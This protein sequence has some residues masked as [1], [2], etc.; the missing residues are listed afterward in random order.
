[1]AMFCSRCT[2]S[3]VHSFLIAFVA[4]WFAAATVAPALAQGQPQA[5]TPNLI[6]EAIDPDVRV[7]LT[8]N[9]HPLAQA[10]Y[11]QGPAPGSMATGRIMLVLKRSDMQEHALRQYLDEL[12]NP[13]SA[14]YHKWLTPETLGAQYGISEGDLATVTAWLQGQGFAIDKVSAARNM[15]LFSGNVTQI[16]QAFTTTIHRYV[17]NGETHYANATDPQIPAALAPVIAAVAPL[18]DFRPH[19]GAVKAGT[20]H[21]DAGTKRISPDITLCDTTTNKCDILFAVP[22]D[23]AT[24]YDTPNST[25]NANYAK[26]SSIVGGKSYDGTGVTI[27]V[28]GDANIVAQD[29]Q[30][31][32]A[33]FLPSSYSANQPKV[34][35]DEN[36]PGITP[37]STEALLDLQVSGGV[38]PGA[39]INFY[40]SAN[41]GLASG[42]ILAI[43]RAISDNNASILN[44]SFGACEPFLGT[45]GNE[46]MMQLWEQAAAQGITVA[47]ATG[48]S[49]SAG[50]DDDTESTSAQYG[51]AVSGFASTAFNVAV[52][53]TDY[54]VLTKEFNTYVGGTNSASNFYGT[55]LSYIPEN[56]WNDSTSVNTGSYTLNQPTM[57]DG[58]TNIVAAGGGVSSCTQSSGEEPDVTC[59]PSTGYPTPAFQKGTTGFTFGNRAV[60]DV[61]FLAANGLYNV[62]WLICSDSQTQGMTATPTSMDCEQTGGQFTSGTTFSGEGGTSAA[63]PAFAGMLAL[64]AQSQGGG[65]LGQANNVLYNLAAQAGLYGKVFHDVTAGNNSVVC[66]AGSPN[67][68]AA[69][70]FISDYNATANYDAASGL[71]S[72]DAAEL[73]ANWTKASFTPTT[74]AFTINGATAP[75]SVKHGTQLDLAAAVSPGSATGDVSFINNSG[76]SATQSQL[77]SFQTLASGKVDLTTPDLPG[78]SKPYNVYAYYGGDVKNAGSLS[79]PVEVTISPEAST[80]LLGLAFTDPSGVPICSDLVQG[81]PPC[82]GKSVGYGVVSVIAAQVKSTSGSNTPATGTISF[83]DTAGTFPSPSVAISSLGVA[84]ITNEDYPNQTLS[85]GSHGLTASYA[86]DGSYEASNSG[87]AYPFTIT[88]GKTH[89]TVTGM[90]SANLV[91]ITANVNTDSIGAPPTGIVEIRV[92]SATLGTFLAYTS[93]GFS[94]DGQ[95]VS[96]YVL[97]IPATTKGLVNGDNT[98]TVSYVGDTNYLASSGSGTVTVSG[99]SSE[100]GFTINAPTSLGVVAGVASGNTG[101]VG[102]LSSAS[103]A[104]SVALSC[105]ITAG[106]SGATS[107]P[108]CAM[109]PTAVTVSGTNIV[110]STMTISTTTTTTLGSYT[111]TV[112]GTGGGTT[113]SA[114]T[115]LTVASSNGQGSFNIAGTG[116]SVSAGA[117][118]GN[119]S[120]ISVTP[121]GGFL[122]SVGLKCSLT[123]SPNGAMNL[124]TCSIPASVLVSGTSAATST[125]TVSSTPP[126]SSALHYPALF[127]GAG[128]TALA[129]LVMLAIPARRRAWRRFLGLVAMAFAISGVIACGGGGGNHNNGG[130][131]TGSYAFTVTGT[132]TSSGSSITASSTVQ[133]MIN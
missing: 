53:G 103:F 3:F 44:V 68:A 121:S 12:Q 22:A 57:I 32:R 102:V 2:L 129:C 20:A 130:T 109:S 101:T 80:L 15:I 6:T 34:I 16:Q 74:T 18:N 46:S 106:P 28:V 87:S 7:T 41:D 55:A 69:N 115:N 123:S 84:A 43:Y 25:L 26:I 60:P 85:V 67:C 90:Q 107:A 110:T 38:A 128:E 35:I 89:V 14:N 10:R 23:A 11:D 33:A 66:T 113:S 24:I 1:M 124:P 40:T 86:G 72:V 56:P 4:T 88:Q 5:A 91:T 30:N 98:V 27:G 125:M 132:A 19:P 63:A 127:R 54:D 36:D 52:G 96:Q 17:V 105:A 59:T 50:C 114:A 116:V 49:G 120:T 93:V 104:G 37:D 126:T 9:V 81:S 42:L 112:T 58:Q 64:V 77:D 65:R 76:V 73:V 75:I 119:T 47:V 79:N 118:M 97:T 131:T 21:Y 62:A 83:A 108:T 71:G 13:N 61:S 133:V 99:L 111:V 8:N 45:S 94:P 29:V 78:S 82:K 100:S 70:S 48:D 31:Y 122:G 51:L 95:I 117:T 39:T 92:G